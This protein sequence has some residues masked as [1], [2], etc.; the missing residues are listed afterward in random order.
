[1]PISGRRWGEGIN[2]EIPQKCAGI[3]ILPPMS[4]PTPT[5]AIPA[6]KHAPYP[7]ELP[8]TDFLWFQGLSD[9]PQRK[10]FESKL[11]ASWGRLVFTKGIIP[12]FFMQ[13]ICGESI[14][15][16]LFALQLRPIVAEVDSISILSLIEI[17]TPNKGGKCFSGFHSSP[18]VRLSFADLERSWSHCLAFCRANSKLSSVMMHKSFPTVVAR[19]P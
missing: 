14:F 5:G 4:F 7:P 17:G 13:M 6:P 8:P 2:P 15:E 10:L 18:I 11:K 12:W 1:M 19:Y 9:L 3:L 16:M